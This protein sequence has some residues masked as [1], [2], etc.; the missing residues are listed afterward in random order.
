[1]IILNF[2]TLPA[3]D[4]FIIE[5]R[6]VCWR[7]LKS[8]EKKSSVS[9][10]NPNFNVLDYSRTEMYSHLLGIFEKLHV[11]D[12]LE[13]TP[14]ELLDFLI[15]VDSSYINT[16]YHSFY[17]AVDVV[18][19]LYYILNDLG[20]DQYLSETDIAALLL[21]ALCHD[22]GHPGYSNIFQVARKTELAVRY[23]DTSV[24]E[25]YSVDITRHLFQKHR[26]LGRLKA[27]N[28]DASEMEIRF[29]NR[30]A[31]LI[32]ST[33]MVRHPEMLDHAH[34]LGAMLT[35]CY[36]GSGDMCTFSS[37]KDEQ[38]L[39]SDRDRLAFSEVIL[40]A[41]DISNTVRPWPI[42]K[43]W[44][45]LIVQEF[46]RQGDAEKEAGLTVSPG[47]DRDQSTQ[48]EIS[49]NFGDLLVKPYYEALAGLL[50]GA[51]ALL[52]ILATNRRSWEHLRQSPDPP[53]SSFFNSPPPPLLRLP[54]ATRSK[55]MLGGRWRRRVT[56]A[57]G[58]LVLPDQ[59]YSNRI[60]KR[61]RYRRSSQVTMQSFCPRGSLYFYPR[62][63]H[64][65]CLA[66]PI[67]KDDPP[68]LDWQLSFSLSKTPLP[69]SS[70]DATCSSASSSSSPVLLHPH[71]A[72]SLGQE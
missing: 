69:S 14:S 6:L 58:T 40:H 44:S 62:D 52:N 56:M 36:G 10:I 19:V 70:S 7:A 66:S 12:T 33:D 22:A 24:L 72:V 16:P 46:F 30:V 26:L 48:A 27:E 39:F 37:R 45:D 65:R 11:L 1:M 38:F 35:A 54:Q 47:M 57:T 28:N 64:H 50:P 9:P 61:E 31:S 3:Q 32:L 43:Q 49:L 53:A 2:N 23:K 67:F 8:T 4:L 29:T 25:S 34:R 71:T 63:Q 20:A 59:Q 68:Q 21:A 17:H 41:A 13:T 60:V 15:D 55:R 51:R 5:R 42:S 18:T